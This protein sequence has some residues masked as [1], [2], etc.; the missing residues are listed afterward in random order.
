MVD[1]ALWACVCSRHRRQEVSDACV[2]ASL[3]RKHCH[4]VQ[5]HLAAAATRQNGCTSTLQCTAPTTLHHTWLEVVRHHA[6][7][8]GHLCVSATPAVS[9]GVVVRAQ[10]LRRRLGIAEEQAARG[11][12]GRSRAHGCCRREC[13]LAG[14]A[15]QARI[16]RCDPAAFLRGILWLLD[17]AHSVS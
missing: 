3:A 11:R 12:R 8:R 1:S 14:C 16:R 5:R 15:D 17:K 13:G 4:Q 10:H 6:V 7:L 2:R 9:A